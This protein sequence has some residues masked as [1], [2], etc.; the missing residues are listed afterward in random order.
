MLFEKVISGWAWRMPLLIV[1]FHHPCKVLQYKIKEIFLSF[2]LNING[3]I[4]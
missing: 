4:I 1:V 3:I 2:I